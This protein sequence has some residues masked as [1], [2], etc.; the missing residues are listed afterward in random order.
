MLVTPVQIRFSDIDGFYHV[1]NSFYSQYLDCGRVAYFDQLFGNEFI[2]GKKKF[3][4]VHIENDFLKPT[5]LTDTIAVYTTVEFIGQKSIKMRQQIIS[6]QGEV[7]V[8]SR[9]ILS[10]FD[11]D[12]QGSFPI[13]PAW[14]IAITS[15][16]GKES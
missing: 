6:S 1:N 14:R 2:S 9:S 11:V 3:V 15:F 16:S 12:K 10:T 7:K 4:L 8:E 5:F 13:P